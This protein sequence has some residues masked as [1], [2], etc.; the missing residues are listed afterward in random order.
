MKY[1][2]IQSGVVQNVIIADTLETAQACAALEG[3]DMT[4][5]VAD[6]FFVGPGF[7]TTD[8]VNFTAPPPSDDDGD[9]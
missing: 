8:N 7:T 2:L 4:V 3:C 9:D 1:V 5:G 6:D